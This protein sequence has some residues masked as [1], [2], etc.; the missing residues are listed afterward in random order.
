MSVSRIPE[1]GLNNT[2]LGHA[3][4]GLEAC[5]ERVVHEL[6]SDY[7]DEVPADVRRLLV[8]LGSFLDAAFA[9]RVADI[10]RRDAKRPLAEVVPIGGRK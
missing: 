4:A 8:A 7:D 6:Q 5:A 9:F 10:K 2:M 1:A 3:V